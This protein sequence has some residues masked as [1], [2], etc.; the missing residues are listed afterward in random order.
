MGQLDDAPH[1]RC[2]SDRV[3]RNREG[4]D[5]RPIGEL[6]LQVVVVERE[7]VRHLD[8]ADDDSEVVRE[9]EPRRDVRVVVELRHE[10][11]VAGAQRAG[12]GPREQEVQRGHARPER[13]LLGTAAEEV[14]RTLPRVLDQL[15]GAPRGLE[16]AADVRVRLA[17]IAG[18][19][20]D[21]LV[22]ALRAAGPVEEGERP[23][24]SAE[25]GAYGGDVECCGRAHRR[26]ATRRPSK[27]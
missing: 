10:H 9:L 5:P 20:V 18:D 22:R 25:P 26:E 3:R 17:E 23:L 27:P 24:E 15:D 14:G 11:L 16:G 4:H 1:V 2:R 12:E 7:L 8:E 19:R 6:P 13:D 21:D